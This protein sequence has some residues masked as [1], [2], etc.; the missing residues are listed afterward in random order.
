MEIG[1]CLEKNLHGTEFISLPMRVV[2]NAA[3]T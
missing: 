2:A 3:L 1:Y